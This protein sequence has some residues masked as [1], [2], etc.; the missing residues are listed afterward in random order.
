MAEKQKMVAPSGMAGLVRY[1]E[2]DSV[3][4]LK[5]EHVLYICAALLAIE[6]AATL[7]FR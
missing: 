2:E 5:P 3:L 6:I 4:K 1:E 7:M